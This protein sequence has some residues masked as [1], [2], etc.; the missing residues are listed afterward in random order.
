MSEIRIAIVGAPGRMGRNL[1]QAVQQ[2]EG[3]ALGA[4]LA[5]SGSSLLGVDAGELAGIGKTGVIVSDDLQKVV[6]D[7]DVLIDF[8]RP[9][10]TLEYLAFC[11]QHNKA[12]VIGTTGFDEAGKAAIRA[13]AEEIGIVFAANFSVGVNLVLNLLQQAAKVMGDYADIEIVEAHHRHKV[14]APSGTALAMGE[15]IADAMKWNLDEHAVYA[16]EGHTGERK[17]QTI[18]FATVRA[19]D[20]VGEHTAMF[21]DIGERVEI[22]HKAS[23]RMTFANGAVKAASWLKNKKSGLYDMRDVLD[24]SML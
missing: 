23:S 9:E 1:I 19:G 7:F 8:T 24:L 16:R 15:A 21:A 11:R 13:A 4:A 12:M 6:N 10:G 3:V 5:R 17:A 22:T 18:G 20:I 2:A 14:D